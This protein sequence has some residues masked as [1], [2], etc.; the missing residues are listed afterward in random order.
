MEPGQITLLWALACASS[1]GGFEAMISVEGGAQQDRVAGGSQAICE[2]IADGLAGSLALNSPVAAL[3]QDGTSVTLT[4]PG[5]EIRAR[6]AIVAMAPDLAGRI[7]YTPRLAGRREQLTNRMASG[8]LTKC[9]AVYERPFWRD[10]GLTGEALSDVGPARDDLRQLAARRRA[11]AR[12]PRAPQVSWSASS[13]APPRPSTRCWASRSAGAASP[14]A[15]SACSAR[16]PATP[17]PTTSRRGPRRPGAPAGRSARRPPGRSP[18]TATS[19][20]AP[21][22]ASTGPAPRPR[23]RG[24][25]TWRGPS[26][27]ASARPARR[28][29]RKDGA[30]ER[31][32]PRDL[33]YAGAA[34]LAG[35]VRAKEVSPEELTDLFLERIERLDPALNAF[36][37]VRVERARAEA[38]AASAGWP[39]ARRPRCSESPSRSRTTG[40]SGSRGRSPPTARRR[41]T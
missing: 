13:P 9:T 4:V 26:R 11:P 10:D 15:S 14:S 32:P 18:P 34:Q 30:C 6:R 1:A 39:R 38:K 2:S 31:R 3:E 37:V 20:A 21:Q 19:S 40:T 16:P 28:S 12:A 35:M 24:A 36:R 8:A 41:S 29:M 7:A 33:A 27:A 22:G 23:R 5:G 25:G 17:A